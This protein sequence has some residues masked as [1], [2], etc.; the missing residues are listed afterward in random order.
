MRSVVLVA[1]RGQQLSD[2]LMISLRHIRMKQ[3]RCFAVSRDQFFQFSLATIDS[4]RLFFHRFRREAIH[5]GLDDAL[6]TRLKF[7]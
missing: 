1:Q 7:C 5:N 3:N 2:C 4:V 6:L